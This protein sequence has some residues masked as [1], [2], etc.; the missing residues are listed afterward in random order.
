M[1]RDDR[2]WRWRVVEPDA[3]YVMASKN[4]SP[5][6]SPLRHGAVPSTDDLTPLSRWRWS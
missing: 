4:R 5:L 6:R 1:M 3:E 2:W